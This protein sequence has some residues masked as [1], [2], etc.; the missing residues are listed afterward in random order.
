LGCQCYML[1]PVLKNNKNIPK[2]NRH[3]R[4]VQ[5]IGFSRFHSSPF[6]LGAKSSE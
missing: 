6:W 3:A 5:F 2:W 4:M 1:D